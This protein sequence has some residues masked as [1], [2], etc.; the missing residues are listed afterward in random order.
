VIEA[1]YNSLANHGALVFV[2]ASN[3]V[4]AKLE[5]DIRMHMARGLKLLGCLEGDSVPSEVSDLLAWHPS[6][7]WAASKAR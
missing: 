6:V 2:G 7:Q 3:D 5:I 4:T 1:A